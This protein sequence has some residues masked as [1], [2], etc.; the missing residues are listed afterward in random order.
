M[1]IGTQITLGIGTPGGIPPF[2]TFGLGP[3][4]AGEP[5]EPDVIEL[6]A[7]IRSTVTVTAGLRARVAGT[8]GLTRTVRLQVER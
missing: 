8:A 2:L 5:T 1:P 4:L 6:T 7:A 3:V